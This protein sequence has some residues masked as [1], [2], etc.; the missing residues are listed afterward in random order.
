MR[1]ANRDRVRAIRKI[2]TL[3]R[4]HVVQVCINKRTSRRELDLISAVIADNSVRRR[5]IINRKTD[6]IVLRAGINT[7]VAS[8]RVDRVIV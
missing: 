1:R 3:N 2:K 8:P 7:I 6:K 4:R 5:Q